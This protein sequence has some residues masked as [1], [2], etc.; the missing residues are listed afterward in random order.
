MISYS[1]LISLSDSTFN[2]R[3]TLAILFTR[4]FFN[5]V[6]LTRVEVVLDTF[7]LAEIKDYRKDHSFCANLIEEGIRLA[8]KLF[9]RDLET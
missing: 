3:S 2:F 8:D 1:A 9:R 7:D 5:S 6:L 4:F